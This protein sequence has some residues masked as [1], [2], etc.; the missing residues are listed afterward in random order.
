MT[1]LAGRAFDA[2]AIAVVTA[3]YR[4]PP[5]CL[6]RQA[7]ALPPS[8]LWILVD[9]SGTG[10]TGP[11]LEALASA[12][13]NTVV[14]HSEGNFGLASA[15][16]RGAR[17]V[18]ESGTSREFLLLLD[19]DSTPWPG[20]VEALLAT[21]CALDRVLP[22]GCVGPDLIDEST[23]MRHG[24]HQVRGPLWSR[25]FP[26]DGQGPVRCDS[27][28]GSGTLVRLAVFERLGGL[29]ESLF[30]DHVDTEWSFRVLDAG[31]GLYGAPAAR[32][33]HEMGEGGIRFWLFGWRVWP[34]RSPRRH[35]FL[36]R[37]SVALLRRDYVPVVWKA[38]CV[39]KLVLAISTHAMLDPRRRQQLSGMAK[40]IRDG[41][42]MP[43]GQGG[44]AP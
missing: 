21:F 37:N 9:D 20:A 25:A 34:R 33:T 14:L 29:D 4:P 19:Q 44:H 7:M 32:F 3:V 28:N 36:F 24:F 40:G 2:S 39:L 10:S 41:F 30:I 35:Y 31:L 23:G 38:W 16:N 26:E 13:P 18:A 12:R 27:L 5:G 6:E 43:A 22:V 11:R 42:R 17:H 8:A 1:W 15:L